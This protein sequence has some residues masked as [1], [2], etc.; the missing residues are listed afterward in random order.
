S[1][2]GVRFAAD[3]AVAPSA[4]G[5]GTVTVNYTVTYDALH[6]L[7]HGDGYRARYELTAI[8][9][10]RRGRQVTGDSWRR[11]VEVPTYEETNGRGTA[12]ADELLFFVLPGRYTLKLEM[13]SLDTRAVGRIERAVTVPRMVPGE[14]SLGTVLF[15]SDAAG[16]GEGAA[17]LVR[18]PARVYG[19]DNPNVR[20]RIPVYGT[21]GSRY[22]L[23]ITV[24]DERGL[25]KKSHQ[26]TLVQTGFLR[27]YVYEFTALDLEVGAHILKVEVTPLPEGRE[28]SARS[29]FRVVTSPLSWGQDEEK[30][31]AQISYVAT[32]DELDLL[33][34]VSPEERGPAW[35]EFWAGRD[36]EPATAVNEFK[37]EFLR[38]LGYANAQFRSIVDGWQT[39]MGR[40]YIQHGEP[41]D[42]DSEPIGQMLSAWEI[43]Y[44]YSEH[45]KY[46]FVDREGFG[47]FVLHEISRI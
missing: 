1:M 17:K 21:A 41:D 38:R 46:V 2:R 35:D 27:E 10:D 13:T 20:V 30:M 45:T 3:V 25:L 32:R 42:I 44:Y 11:T 15:E 34:S 43:W 8:L 40:I 9:Y 47:E 14:L 26:D 37:V 5:E 23:R 19:E 4:N 28:V 16:E 7:R 29:R 31:L 24:K 6:F 36:A 33:T 12:G 18:N 39:D 22:A